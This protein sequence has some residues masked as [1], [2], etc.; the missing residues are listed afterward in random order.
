[1]IARKTVQ[2]SADQLDHSLS[3][4]Q[5]AEFI[6][7]QPAM[8]DIEYRFKHALTHDQAYNS[9]LTDR[10]QLLHERT[11]QAIEAS[12][13]DRLEDHYDDLARHYRLSENAAKAIEYIRLAGKQAMD[14]GA[15]AQALAKVEPALKLLPGLPDE[16][17]RL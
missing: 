2:L 1:E 9:L 8:G 10:R 14:R 15:Y 13:H 12:Y 11:A 7:E 4:L 3:R 17:E 5:E 6:Y 16:R